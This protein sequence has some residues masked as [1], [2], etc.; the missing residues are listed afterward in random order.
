MVMDLGR[1]W[2][3]LAEEGGRG[4]LAWPRMPRRDAYSQGAS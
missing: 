4:L 2:M 1:R 3:K